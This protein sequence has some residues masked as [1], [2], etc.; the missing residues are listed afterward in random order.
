MTTRAM[1]YQ[2][3]CWWKTNRRKT[4]LRDKEKMIKWGGMLIYSL[5][6][7]MEKIQIIPKPVNL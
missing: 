4:S 7:N 5:E 2:V 6:I 1:Y 3:S